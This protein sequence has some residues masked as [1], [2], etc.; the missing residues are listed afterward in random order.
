MRN[1][2][3]TS[4]AVAAFAAAMTAASSASAL[5]LRTSQDFG[6]PADGAF[7]D[8]VITITPDM[9][10]IGVLR[11]QTVKFIDAS[12]GQSFVWRFDTAET[13]FDLSQVAPAAGA[14]HVKTYVWDT[15]SRAAG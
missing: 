3:R 12:T 5:A 11:N 7:V 1:T 14:I 13:N 6:K 8:R 10:P 15:T 9:H 4:V 2:L